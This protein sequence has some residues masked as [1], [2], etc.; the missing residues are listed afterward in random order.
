[1]H[2]IYHFLDLKIR[3]YRMKWCLMAHLNFFYNLINRSHGNFILVIK[4][5][6]LKILDLPAKIFSSILNTRI[7]CKMCFAR[8]WFKKKDFEVKILDFPCKYSNFSYKFSKNLLQILDLPAKNF[9]SIF[10]TR[11]RCKM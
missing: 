3:Y 9:P 4:K 5:F 6:I 11:I 7:R 1:L 8:F 2:P 10:N